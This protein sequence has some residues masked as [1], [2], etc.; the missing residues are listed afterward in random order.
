MTLAS[1]ELGHEVSRPQRPQRLQQV[2]RGP[3]MVAGHG[4]ADRR[5]PRDLPVVEADG[6]GSSCRFRRGLG[7]AAGHGQRDRW[8]S[9]S[10]LAMV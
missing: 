10:P 5:H 3:R 6:D 7:A 9:F 2:Q 1:V 4:E 8:P